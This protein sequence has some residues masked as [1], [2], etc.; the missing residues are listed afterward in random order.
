M[1][2]E[3]IVK[4]KGNKVKIKAATG[5]CEHVDKLATITDNGNGYTCKF[6]SSSSVYADVFVSLDY[7][8]A[9]YLF[10]ALSKFAKDWK[11]D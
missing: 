10:L 9:E 6:H 7:S 2:T 8:Q 5:Y 1:S 3:E 11:Q 4:R